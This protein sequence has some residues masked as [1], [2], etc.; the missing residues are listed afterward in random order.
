MMTIMTK[1][2]KEK[3]MTQELS[4]ILGTFHRWLG[5]HQSES[6]SLFSIGLKGK[7]VSAYKFKFDVIEK[8]MFELSVLYTYKKV[9]INHRCLQ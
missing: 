5:L 6:R 7:V 1:I 4:A 9:F 8:S 2:V 3:V